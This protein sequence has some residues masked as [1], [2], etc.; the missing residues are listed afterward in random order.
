MTE[1]LAVAPNRKARER[2]EWAYGRLLAS[3]AD[4][5]VAALG[6]PSARGA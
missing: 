4:S 3:S 6:H 2:A 5:F 1:A